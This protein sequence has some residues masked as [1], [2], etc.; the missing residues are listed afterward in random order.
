MPDVDER[1]DCDERRLSSE[2]NVEDQRRKSTSAV[3]EILLYPSQPRQGVAT[4]LH[5]PYKD[6]KTTSDIN[7]LFKHHQ[8]KLA[9]TGDSSQNVQGKSSTTVSVQ[10][11]DVHQREDSP[12]EDPVHSDHASSSM[13]PS[14]NAVMIGSTAV[15]YKDMPDKMRQ[16]YGRDG[17]LPPHE[18]LKFNN[19][20][21]A[22]RGLLIGTKW[23]NDP[24]RKKSSHVENLSRIVPGMS[25]REIAFRYSKQVREAK[26]TEERV[27]IA[28]KAYQDAGKDISTEKLLTRIQAVMSKDKAKERNSMQDSILLVEST[29]SSSSSPAPFNEGRCPTCPVNR[30]GKGKEVVTDISDLSRN[31]RNYLGRLGKLP[32]TAQLSHDR[33]SQL[34]KQRHMKEKVDLSALLS[35]AAERSVNLNYFDLPHKERVEWGREG[36]LPDYAQQQFEKYSNASKAQWQGPGRSLRAT[37]AK[38]RGSLPRS[39]KDVLEREAARGTGNQN[40][41]DLATKDGGREA[42]RISEARSTLPLFDVEKATP[43]SS[44]RLVK[45][46]P[47]P[48]HDFDLNHRYETQGESG[49]HRAAS[50]DLNSS[51]SH[52]EDPHIHCQPDDAQAMWVPHKHAYVSSSSTMKK[53]KIPASVSFTGETCLSGCSSAYKAFPMEGTPQQEACRTISQPQSQA[54]D[55]TVAAALD[56]QGRNR[57][58]RRKLGRARLL[59][60]EEQAIFDRHSQLTKASNRTYTPRSEESKK[61]IS[62]GQ[63]KSLQRKMAVSLHI[64]DRMI[65]GESVSYP[66]GVRASNPEMSEYE[67]SRLFSREVLA[68]NTMEERVSILRKAHAAAGRDFSEANLRKKVMNM[69]SSHTRKAIKKAAEEDE[70]TLSPSTSRKASPVV[71]TRLMRESSSPCDKIGRC[72]RSLC[73]DE[74][75]QLFRLGGLDSREACLQGK[76]QRSVFLNLDNYKKA[77]RKGEQRNGKAEQGNSDNDDEAPH[78]MKTQIGSKFEVR[79]RRTLARPQGNGAAEPSI[80][81]GEELEREEDA[82]APPAKRSLMNISVKFKRSTAEEVL[83]LKRYK[84]T[85]AGRLGKLPLDMQNVLDR[86][87]EAIREGRLSAGYI[88]GPQEEKV[89]FARDEDDE[90]AKQKETETPHEDEDTARPSETM[91]VNEQLQHFDLLRLRKRSLLPLSM[92]EDDDDYKDVHRRAFEEKS[93]SPSVSAASSQVRQKL[94]AHVRRK[95]L[96]K[97]AASTLTENQRKYAAKLRLLPANTVEELSG[98]L[99][100][101]AGGVEGAARE[102]K[103]LVPGADDSN[104]LLPRLSQA[105]F[106]HLTKKERIRYGHEGRLPEYEQVKFENRSDAKQGVQIGTRRRSPSTGRKI[107]EARLDHHQLQTAKGL[108][109]EANIMNGKATLAQ[110]SALRWRVSRRNK[111]A[112]DCVE[113]VHTCKYLPSY[114][115]EVKP[116]MSERQVAALISER[117]QNAETEQAAVEIARD[118]HLAAGRTIPDSVLSRRV[119]AVRATAEKNKR[120]LKNK[121]EERE[122]TS[123]SVLKTKLK[124]DF[125]VGTSSALTYSSDDRR[126][127]T[128]FS[129]HD[130]QGGEALVR[131]TFNDHQE[132]RT[133]LPSPSSQIGT[134]Q[135]S[136]HHFQP[137][138]LSGRLPA[139]FEPSSNDQCD[140]SAFLASSSSPQQHLPPIDPHDVPFLTKKERIRLGHEGRLPPHDQAHF[141]ESSRRNS[142]PNRR[143]QTQSEETKRKI[144]EGQLAHHILKTAKGLTVE[145]LVMNGMGSHKQFLRHRATLKTRFK[146]SSLKE[147]RGGKAEG[148]DFI[149]LPAYPTEPKPGMSERQVSHLITRQLQEAHTLEDAIEIARKAHQIAGRVFS[150]DVLELRVRAVRNRGKKK[151]ASTSD[152]AS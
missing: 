52:D 25:D 62:E 23:A 1:G 29:P 47:T 84:K 15:D 106:D 145:A 150:D 26:S 102:E 82:D 142:T 87:S 27:R 149:A 75:A 148:N 93:S 103:G 152:H 128:P 122:G 78:S 129:E 101:A 37:K 51:P 132:S 110:I 138:E 55:L 6:K 70:G 64:K 81:G 30:A 65:K 60:D 12:R 54:A 115:T 69:L 125:D 144:S 4:E 74:R 24:I 107:S 19:R 83:H 38:E 113:S 58:Q 46:S 97:E 77:E 117:V 95:T 135:D 116:G 35:A 49:L 43:S 91:H 92:K 136:T 141:N 94:S 130:D 32:P 63:K 16:R 99:E 50:F 34:Q 111:N 67:V 108:T 22:H 57:W 147:E 28:R 109:V 3:K 100:G 61:K 39:R 139:Y 13:P 17:A 72:R 123:V 71:A 121:L 126:V 134:T 104:Q 137:E 124:H 36:L 89:S 5:A 20:S 18:Q 56:A 79:Q 90:A 68:A 105:E 133:Y 85:K 41:L 33:A 2:I 119:K 10:R 98:H 112:D 73:S 42:Q 40:L 9:G 45:R 114:L 88:S 7:D 14:V 66:G 21:A 59:P 140:E 143:G 31:Q 80:R 8:R 76:D 48:V 118:G 131:R 96:S 86:R 127:A 11:E 151:Q 120:K 146:G 44:R 53:D